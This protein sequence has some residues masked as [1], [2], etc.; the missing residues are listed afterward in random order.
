MILQMT[1]IHGGCR[2]TSGQDGG[3]GFIVLDAITISIMLTLNINNH[4]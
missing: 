2:M 4:N 1:N 3:G